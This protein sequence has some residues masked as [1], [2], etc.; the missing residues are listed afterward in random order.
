MKDDCWAASYSESRAGMTLKHTE[1]RNEA[2]SLDTMSAL[3]ILRK[4]NDADRTVAEAVEEA[5][6]RLASVVGAAVH[7]ISEGGR[8]IYAGAGSS[9]RLAA[10]DAI[11]CVPTFG[12]TAGTVLWTLAGGEGAF[13]QDKEDVEDDSVAGRE[14]MVELGVAEGDLVVGVSA[15]GNTPYTLAAM[16]KAREYGA[17]TACV[18][19]V[20]G[21][22]MARVADHPIELLT[23][24]E[25]LAGSTRL[26]AG[27]AQKMALN[28]ISTATMTRV[29]YVYEDLMVGVVAQNAK[30]RQRAGRI[31][32]EITGCS[33]QES[34]EALERA[35]HDVRAAVLLVDGVGSATAAHRLL[36]ESRGS[37]RRARELAIFPDA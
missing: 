32:R 5:L 4:M 13:A 22:E 31:V 7:S 28:M 29:G 21:S 33:E 12:V 36:E 19:N 35:K 14:K 2:S 8:L 1:A 30:L 23:G 25:T 16:Q 11:E 18:V 6:P 15:S 24:P 26:K 10:Q 27:T 20:E 37:L 17:R 3:G 9:G 34:R